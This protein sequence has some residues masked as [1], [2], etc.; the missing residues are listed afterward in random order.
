MYTYKHIHII[1]I[2]PCSIIIIIIS[3][4]MKFIIVIVFA[5]YA[6]DF[7][8]LSANPGTLYPDR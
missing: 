1:W 8:E 7:V 6:Y 3:N 4:I 2:S 5:G